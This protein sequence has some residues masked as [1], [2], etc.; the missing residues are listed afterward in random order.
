MFLA[1]KNINH[2]TERNVAIGILVVTVAALIHIFRHPFWGVRL[3]GF[4]RRPL[5]IMALIIA[6]FFFAPA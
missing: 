4:F 1:F 2:I 5:A 3:R 6:L